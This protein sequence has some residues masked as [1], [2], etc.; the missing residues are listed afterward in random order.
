MTDTNAVDI[1]RRNVTNNHR[2]RRIKA[3]GITAFPIAILVAF[4]YSK[5]FKETMDQSVAIAIASLLGSAGTWVSI[6]FVDLRAVI[7][8]YLIKKR[9]VRSRRKDDLDAL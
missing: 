2:A 1:D 4:L 5:L 6:C 7:C 3:G 8:G 9:I